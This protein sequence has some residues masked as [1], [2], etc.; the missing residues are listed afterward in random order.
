MVL[1]VTPYCFRQT[2]RKFLLLNMGYGCRTHAINSAAGIR[3]GERLG[4]E[5]KSFIRC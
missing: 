3:P 2:A 4:V 1:S 5:L